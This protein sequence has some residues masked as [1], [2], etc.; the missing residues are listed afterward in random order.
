MLQRSPLTDIRSGLRKRSGVITKFLGGCSL[1]IVS[2]VT[3]FD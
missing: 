1:V 3:A 2:F